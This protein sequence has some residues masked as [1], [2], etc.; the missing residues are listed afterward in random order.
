[1]SKFKEYWKGRISK[2][3]FDEFSRTLGIVNAGP[4]PTSL[5]AEQDLEWCA[6]SDCEMCGKC[7]VEYI[8]SSLDGMETVELYNGRVI[9]QTVENGERIKEFW[10]FGIPVTFRTVAQARQFIKDG[11]PG[12]G[13]S[14][15][16]VVVASYK[17]K[18]IMQLVDM[19]IPLLHFEVMGS[20]QVVFASIEEAKRFIDSNTNKSSEDSSDD[21]SITTTTYMGYVIKKISKNTYSVE[22]I[23]GRFSSLSAAKDAISKDHS[24]KN[25][26]MTL[27]L[28]KT[29]EK[30]A[31]MAKNAFELC[32]LNLL[33]VAE[34][35]QDVE[36]LMGPDMVDADGHV[37]GCYVIFAAA[38][39]NP[40]VFMHIEAAREYVDSVLG[41]RMGKGAVETTGKQLVEVTQ[42][43][44]HVDE[45]TDSIVDNIKAIQLKRQK[46]TIA[47]REKEETAK[48]FK[49]GWAAI[50]RKGRSN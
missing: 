21:G 48:S 1:M 28:H 22:G 24:N 20:P 29:G 47:A 23:S 16:E 6:D 19:G 36:I 30:Y 50:S 46:A 9:T 25:K 4:V 5:L 45:P 32:E 27:E 31:T 40:Q 26:S 37:V 11:M 44:K 7:I 2:D 33:D 8:K 12:F 38:D 34:M 49:E 42:S 15:D 3:E 39:G 13:K 10:V 35:Y 14:Q 41:N 17:G 43:A 18:T